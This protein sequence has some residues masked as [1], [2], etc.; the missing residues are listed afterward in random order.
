MK[1]LLALLLCLSLVSAL[2]L[3]G[4]RRIVGGTAGTG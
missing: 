2:G 4:R 1:K 3:D